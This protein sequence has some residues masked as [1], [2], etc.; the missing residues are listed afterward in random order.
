M[1]TILRDERVIR[2]GEVDE[3]IPIG[4][5]GAGVSPQ[6]GG[7]GVQGVGDHGGPAVGDEVGPLDDAHV[8]GGDDEWVAREPRGELLPVGVGRL[9]IEVQE[10]A[11]PGVVEREEDAAER[12]GVPGGSGYEE[13]DAGQRRGGGRRGRGK[14]VFDEE[15]R[16]RRGGGGEGER[17]GGEGD[18]EEERERG[19]D[20]QGEQPP[21]VHGGGGDGLHRRRRQQ[22]SVMVL[23][24][25][26]GLVGQLHPYIHRHA[27]PR[28]GG[29]AN[30]STVFFFSNFF[31]IVCRPT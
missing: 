11:V 25:S 5:A 23:Y 8:G 4:A 30:L 9:G 31:F 29:V 27:T 1:R 2:G 16:G 3:P 20:G 15:A 17:E 18:E 19:A 24:F 10:V 6:E 12:R 26:T 14:L 13:G 28:H 21:A 7:G 22:S